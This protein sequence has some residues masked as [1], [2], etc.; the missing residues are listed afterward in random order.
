MATATAIQT[1]HNG[2]TTLEAE[3]TATETMEAVITSGLLKGKTVNL[4][5]MPDGSL[6]MSEPELTSEEREAWD[7]LME[8]SKHAEK[9]ALEL[10]ESVDKLNATLER[11]EAFLTRNEA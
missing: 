3:A 4:T 7:E 6:D 11:V 10:Q 5:M 2:T 9:S 8:V 1:P